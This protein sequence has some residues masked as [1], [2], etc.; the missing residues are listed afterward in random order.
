MYTMSTILKSCA[1]GLHL[2]HRGFPKDKEA[3]LGGRTCTGALS[4]SLYK[5][6]PDPGAKRAGGKRQQR[7][8]LCM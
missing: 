1:T 3:L 4:R 8:R 2:L 7:A 6:L 5:P